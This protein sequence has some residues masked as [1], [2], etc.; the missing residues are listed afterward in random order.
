M[1]SLRLVV[2]STH[3]PE[4]EALQHGLAVLLPTWPRLHTARLLATGRGALV[5]QPASALPRETARGIYPLYRKAKDAPCMV[6]AGRMRGPTD[7]L[8]SWQ[9]DGGCC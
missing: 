6:E 5:V 3:S 4:A 8:R 7:S 1:G 2:Q 9:P